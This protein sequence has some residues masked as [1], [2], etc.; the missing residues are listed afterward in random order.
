[1]SSTNVRISAE[2]RDTLRRLAREEGAPMQLILDKAVERYRREKF[3]RDAN[4]DFV[5]LRKNTKAWKEELKERDLW[6]QTIGD[7]LEDA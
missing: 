5:A 1:M 6:E 4:E 7:G 3:L 2:S